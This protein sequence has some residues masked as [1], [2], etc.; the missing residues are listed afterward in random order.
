MK[1]IIQIPCLDEEATLPDTIASLPRRIEGIDEIEILIVDDGSSDRTSEIARLSGAHHVVRFVSNR[2]L[3]RAFVAGIHEALQRGADIIV[4]TDADNQ[5]QGEDIERLVRPI[6]ERTADVTIG[7]RQIEGIEDFSWLKKRLQ[8]LGSGVVRYISGTQVEDATSGFRAF[9]REAALKLNVVSDFSYTLETIIQLGQ[10]RDKIV[11]VPI[12]TNRK[13]RD[14]RLARTMFHY[15][16]SSG[17]TIVRIAAMYQPL[18]VFSLIGGGFFL[19]GMA[20]GARFVAYWML[21]DGAGKVQSLILAA[22]LM[23]VGGQIFM[24]GV[25]G[26]LIAAN[27]KLLESLKTEVM[28]RSGDS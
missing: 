27:R 6:L 11:S 24:M 1:L 21:G 16:R 7:A 25:L 28:R 15:I 26:D 17:A 18:K 8:R 4:N 20:I 12:R 22:T 10:T 13:K 23:I 14:S 9:S 2:G 3:A 5:Y 19:A